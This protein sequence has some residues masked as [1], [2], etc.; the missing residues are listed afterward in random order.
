MTKLL[1]VQSNIKPLGF[2]SIKHAAK[3]TIIWL[4]RQSTDDEKLIFFS[5]TSDKSLLSRIY[6]E[7]KH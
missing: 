1:D 5:Y 6:K 4:K 7:Q 3:N 2:S